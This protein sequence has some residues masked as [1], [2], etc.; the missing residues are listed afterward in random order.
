MNCAVYKCWKKNPLLLCKISNHKWFITERQMITLFCTTHKS[1][2]GCANSAYKMWRLHK[3]YAFAHFWKQPQPQIKLQLATYLKCY[4]VKLYL[5]PSKIAHTGTDKIVLFHKAQLGSADWNSHLCSLKGRILIFCS[6]FLFRVN[7][8]CL[9]LIN[10]QIV[11]THFVCL[12]LEDS[13][14]VRG[15]GRTICFVDRS[16]LPIFYT[17]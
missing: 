7:G 1:R 14:G 5:L 9:F 15:R 6:L 12:R 17:E 10:C 2:K 13:G 3:V 11:R 16:L 4:S 8:K